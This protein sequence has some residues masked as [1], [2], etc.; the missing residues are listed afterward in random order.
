[1]VVN[2]VNNVDTTKH[3]V[4]LFLIDPIHKTFI[5]NFDQ[6]HW[7]LPNLNTMYFPHVFLEKVIGIWCFKNNEQFQ[8]IANNLT[9]WVAQIRWWIS[10]NQYVTI[11]YSGLNKKYKKCPPSNI[12]PHEILIWHLALVRYGEICWE[13]VRYGAI[14]C[15][16]VRYGEI[17]ARISD[18]WQAMMK[19]IE[20]WYIW[21]FGA[22]WWNMVRFCE[23]L[24]D[25]V[26][27]GRIWWDSV[28]FYEIWWDSVRFSEI[29][30]DLLVNM[31]ADQ[32]F[33]DKIKI[34][35]SPD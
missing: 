23:I 14:R 33:L 10:L 16:S 30:W 15:D 25:M 13:S 19:L 7:K 27:F 24:W 11:K 6:H 20:I 31:A 9:I 32:P 8:N 5:F 1:M 2:A 29:W 22:I 26:R 28:R 4:N 21:W 12:V 3:S 18:I 17:F 34:S 35:N